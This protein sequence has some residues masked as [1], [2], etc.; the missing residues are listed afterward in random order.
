MK[1]S[2]LIEELAAIEHESWAHWQRYVH[3][4]CLAGPDGSLIIPPELV[5]RWERQISTRYEDLSEKEKN[6]DREQVQRVVPVVQRF[7]EARNS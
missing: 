6:S 7:V 1:L 5:M 2:D 3:D 4:Q